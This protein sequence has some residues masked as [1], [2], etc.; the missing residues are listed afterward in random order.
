NDQPASFEGALAARLWTLDEPCK[1]RHTRSQA[2][3]M[4][5]P[6]CGTPNAGGS[7]RCIAC[8]MPPSGTATGATGMTG[9]PA[10]DGS[11]TIGVPPPPDDATRHI[12]ASPLEAETAAIRR[13]IGDRF[14]IIKLL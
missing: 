6:H 11:T 7:G 5:C 12:S 14:H 13:V 8:G 4:F 3:Q 10:A 1:M 9:P 2:P